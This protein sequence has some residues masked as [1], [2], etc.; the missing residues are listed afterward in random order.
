MPQDFE[1]PPNWNV[2]RLIPLADHTSIRIGGP[3]DYFVSVKDQNIFIDLY[4]FCRR[5]GIRFLVLGHGTNVFF[6]E[7]GFRG[8]VAVL[9]FDR[10]ATIAGNAIVAEAGAALSDLVQLCAENALTGCEFA[11]GIPGTIGGAIYGNAGA[12]G[13]ALSERLIRAKVMTDDGAIQ[14]ATPDFFMFAY[15]D[16][17][18][19]RNGAMVLQAEFQFS[20]GDS[21]QI[22]TRMQEIL[23]LRRAKLPPWETP[24]AGSYFKNLK[25]D[26]G[27]PTPA[28]KLLDAVGSKQISVG[29]AAVHPKH[30]NI[31]YNRGHATATQM[32][33]LEEILRQ[34]V[35][36]RF[37]VNLEREVM[38]IESP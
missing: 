36:E 24:T 26:Q 11:S 31:F 17:E 30:A 37:G 5:E 38:Y 20:R 21:M 25:D 10:M 34:R 33:E 19:K 8:L 4:G 2:Q 35:K 7:Y 32:L 3:A 15:R 13:H 14:I 16:S 27:N 6:P 29:D 9:Q 22:R 1:F 12:Y 23:E 28:A 18:L